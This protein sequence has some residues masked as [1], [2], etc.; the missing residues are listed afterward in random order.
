MF[1]LLPKEEKYFDLFNRMASHTTECALL[2]KK[3]FEDFDRHAEYADQIKA[4]EH[5]CDEITHDIIRRLN[6]TFITPIDREDIHALASEIDDIV[7]YI[8]YTARRTVLYRVEQSTEHARQ[9]TAVLVKIVASLENAVAALDGGNGRVIQECITIHA[10]ENEGDALHHAAVEKLFSEEKDP[11]K[12]IKWKELYETLERSI[13]KCEDVA[14]VL[15]AIV[16]K[17]A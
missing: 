3:L 10:L 1:R 12:I 5:Q 16:L 14:N 11:I 2:L 4:V 7:D 8:E 15:E 13:D 6:Q 9:L 17:N